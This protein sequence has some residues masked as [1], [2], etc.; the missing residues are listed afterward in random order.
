MTQLPLGRRYTEQQAAEELGVG[1]YTLQRIRRAGMIG[2][3]RPSPRKIVYY[4]RHLDEYR[5]QTEVAPKCTS[6]ESATTTCAER[7]TH[8]SGMSAGMIQPNAVPARDAAALASLILR[9]RR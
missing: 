1:F 5:Q 7:Q 8:P 4:D 2:Y 6:T 3:V 9:P